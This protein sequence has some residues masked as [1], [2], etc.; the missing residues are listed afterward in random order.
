MGVFLNALFP[1][2]PAIWRA[3]RVEIRD[4]VVVFDIDRKDM[5]G[6]RSNRLDSD[7]VYANSDSFD[8]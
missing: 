8:S 3:D 5:L 2:R 7:K 1:V 6:F 4:V